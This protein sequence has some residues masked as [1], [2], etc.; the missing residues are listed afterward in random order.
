MPDLTCR[1]HFDPAFDSGVW[2]GPVPQP[3]ATVGQHWVGLRGLVGLLETH[4]GLAGPSLSEARRAAALGCELARTR[5]FWSGSAEVDPLGTARRLLHWR[6][7]LMMG[8]W[9]GQPASPRLDDLWRLTR[10]FPGQPDRLQALLAGLE[11]QGSPLD[12]VLV[13]SRPLE[14]LAQMVMAQLPTRAADLPDSP[15]RGDLLAA[16]QGGFQPYGDGTLQLVRPGGPLEAA[17]EVAAWL[18]AWPDL[19]STVI[20]NPSPGLDRALHQA[21]LPTTGAPEGPG[22]SGLL[23]L[24]PL[25]LACGWDPPDPAQ[26]LQLLTATLTPIPRDVRYLLIKALRQWPAVGS[27][28][29]RENLEAALAEVEDP[30]KMRARVRN[31]LHGEA[32]RGGSWPASSARRRVDHLATWLRGRLG[33]EEGDREPW[34][35]ALQACSEFDALVAVSGLEALSESQ[36]QRLLAQALAAV[37]PAGPH[38]AQAGL[39]A[40]GHPG[41][42]AGPARLVVWWDFSLSTVQAPSSLPLTAEEQRRLQAA[43]V[44]LP[45]PGQ[46]AHLQAESWRRPLTQASEALLLV[47][48]E[49]NSQGAEEFPH[50]LWDEVRVQA[51]DFAHRL[52][53]PRPFGPARPQRSLRALKTPARARRYWTVAPEDLAPRPSES[54]NSLSTLIG[55]PF[56]WALRYHGS[57]EPGGAG[58]LPTGNLLSSSL[59]HEVLERVFLSAPSSP[60]QARQ[61]AEALFDELAPTVAA[62][63]F[64]PGADAERAQA[65]HVTAGA[66]ESLARL[67]QEAKMRVLEVEVRSE[68]PGLDGMVNG[69]VDLVV[70]PPET[71]L[72]LK[73]SGSK[74]FEKLLQEG[75]AYQLATYS[76]LRDWAPAGYFT[77]VD[78]TLQMDRPGP[79]GSGPALAAPPFEETWRGLEAAVRARRD[80]MARGVLEAPANPDEEG[81]T[82]TQESGLVEGRL[83]L[84]PDCGWCDMQVLCG[85]ALERSE[86][87]QDED[88]A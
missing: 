44:E 59:A 52:E 37:T 42:L 26:V 11:S 30:E 7:T 64:L 12:E 18:A 61:A 76:Y 24:L 83:V 35:T 75:T 87:V 15:A 55:C 71:I 73:W 33:T 58:G 51:G 50:P 69:R 77:L 34:H 2:P 63:L 74:K 78:G 27:P 23:Q 4:L 13:F 20:L 85:L 80:E 28:A 32:P 10:D 70:G 45:D 19:A 72:D 46:A 48:P 60:Q 21:G 66:A 43:G 3:G 17:E 38:P 6:D 1:A 29:W 81:E 36:L 25:V 40:V 62:P 39:H 56:A 79:L 54:P 82:G 14:K 65:R 86:E 53:A 8:G 31:L 9:Q 47:C 88:E 16:R 5:G 49:R 22:Q 41:S 68:K 57:V 67:L 84:A